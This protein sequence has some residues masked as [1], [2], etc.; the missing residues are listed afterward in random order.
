MKRANKTYVVIAR[1]QDAYKMGV[2]RR[3]WFAMRIKW[4]LDSN[5]FKDK[6][7]IFLP[8][9]APTPLSTHAQRYIDKA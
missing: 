6:F 3:K 1:A 4:C 7:Y 8:A 9:R 2:P 5:L